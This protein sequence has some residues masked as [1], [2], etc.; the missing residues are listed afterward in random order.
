MN[1]ERGSKRFL[2]K[3][4]CSCLPSQRWSCR[5]K[6]VRWHTTNW[7]LSHAKL[8]ICKVIFSKVWRSSITRTCI[9]R[10]RSFGKQIKTGSSL[11][12]CLRS[13]TA[14]RTIASD[15]L[16]HLILFCRIMTSEEPAAE[17]SL[18]ASSIWSVKYTLTPSSTLSAWSSKT[19]RI[20]LTFYEK[21]GSIRTLQGTWLLRWPVKFTWK[22]RRH[23]LSTAKTKVLMLRFCSIYSKISSARSS[24][25]S[26]H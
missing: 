23:L 11:T 21:S 17:I 10:R 3:S 19:T 24:L 6:F 9:K 20:S 8:V 13:S 15:R 14:R 22:Y 5:M 4:W 2:M 1:S 12:W 18:K 25:I 16:C 26:N 7:T